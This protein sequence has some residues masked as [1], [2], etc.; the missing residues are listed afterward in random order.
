MGHVPADLPL[1]AA[2]YSLLVVDMQAEVFPGELTDSYSR[3][4]PNL[5]VPNGNDAWY[6]A[7]LLEHYGV[8][9]GGWNDLLVRWHTNRDAASQLRIFDLRELVASRSGG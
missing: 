6:L 4:T 8:A 3:A 2:R 1:L 5:V 9:W 7:D